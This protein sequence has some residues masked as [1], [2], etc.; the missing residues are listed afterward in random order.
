MEGHILGHAVIFLSP[1]PAPTFL[2]YITLKSL[3]PED[4]KLIRGG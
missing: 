4:V 2:G 3:F 1:Q